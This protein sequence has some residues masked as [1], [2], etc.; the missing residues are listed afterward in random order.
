M[1]LKKDEFKKLLE[2]ESLRGSGCSLSEASK[3]QVYKTLCTVL[4]DLLAEERKNF[5]DEVTSKAKK[6]RIL[7]IM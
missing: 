2:S 4:R 6:Q 1:N 5:S 7:M 3:I